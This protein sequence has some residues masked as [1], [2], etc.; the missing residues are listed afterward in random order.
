MMSTDKNN[1]THNICN[2]KQKTEL[3]FHAKQNVENT[4]PRIENNV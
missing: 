3:I 4:V 1:L 2:Q